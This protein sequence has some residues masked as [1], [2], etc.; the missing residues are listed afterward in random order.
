MCNKTVLLM[1]AFE[2]QKSYC[3]GH[4]AT[5]YYHHLL[6]LVWPFE[7]VGD[8]SDGRILSIRLYDMLSGWGPMHA[9]LAIQTA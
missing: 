1:A 8:L 5:W 2:L 6:G 3:I 7:V 4:K 9:A